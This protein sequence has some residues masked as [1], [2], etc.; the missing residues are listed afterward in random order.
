M[1]IK[2]YLRNAL[3]RWFLSSNEFIYHYTLVRSIL[4]IAYDR[5]LWW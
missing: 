3:S 5:H 1:V 2:K 4:F